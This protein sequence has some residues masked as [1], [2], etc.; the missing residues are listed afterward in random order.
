MEERIMWSRLKEFPHCL[1]LIIYHNKCFIYGLLFLML[2][3]WFL[4]FL[5]I[6]AQ[7]ILTEKCWERT[8]E[9]SRPNFKGSLIPKKKAPLHIWLWNMPQKWTAKW[10][11]YISKDHPNA[12]A[13]VSCYM[14]D[15][16][17]N[18]TPENKCN[19]WFSFP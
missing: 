4:H 12:T 16:W 3:V 19:T 6:L 15:Y 1:I 7:G 5:K 18:P 14:T 10:G 8:L 9:N 11:I 17:V 2:L 13:I